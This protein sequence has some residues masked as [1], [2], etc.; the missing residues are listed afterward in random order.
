MK[1]NK[2][3]FLFVIIIIIRTNCLLCDSLI[4]LNLPEV[5]G[6]KKKKNSF[7]ACV[8]PIQRPLIRTISLLARQASTN[9]HSNDRNIQIA[10]I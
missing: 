9:K 1:T 6:K 7:N 10:C 2:M 8:L 4:Y 5:E 3:S